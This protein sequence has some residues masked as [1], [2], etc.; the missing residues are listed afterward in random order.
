[1]QVG[2]LEMQGGESGMQGLRG[3]WGYRERVWDAGREYGIQ[4]NGSGM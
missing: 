1:M 3:V 4:G 2:G